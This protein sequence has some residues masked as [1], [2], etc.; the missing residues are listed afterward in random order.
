MRSPTAKE[1]F[2]F[3]CSRGAP[4]FRSWLSDSVLSSIGLDALDVARFPGTL[5]QRRED[6]PDARGGR[7]RQAV[8]AADF[9]GRR[10]LALP[11]LLPVEGDQHAG[12]SG[13]R[14]ADEGDRLALRAARGDN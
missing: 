4:C 11:A 6:V 2:S 10:E 1:V 12:R 7:N 5:A 3:L 8:V 9:L 14:G 13:P